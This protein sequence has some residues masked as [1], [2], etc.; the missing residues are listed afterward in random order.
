[1]STQNLTGNRVL[2]VDDEWDIRNLLE[3]KLETE[4]LAYDSA[5]NGQEAID[6]LARESYGCVLLDLM[7]PIVDGFAVLEWIRSHQP[8]RLQRVVV[9]TGGSDE[10]VGRVD[11]GVFRV[12]RKPVA[13]REVMSTVRACLEAHASR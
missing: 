2:I 13:L 11:A 5:A 12:L 4:S 8:D 7:M 6:C 9:L 10:L 3:L 1:M